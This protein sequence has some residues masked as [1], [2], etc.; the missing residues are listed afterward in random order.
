MKLRLSFR[1]L[2]LVSELKNGRTC[3]QTQFLSGK[4][5]I[6]STSHCQG[7]GFY[8]V[9]LK[10]RTQILVVRLEGDF[11]RGPAGPRWTW[12][13][14]NGISLASEETKESRRVAAWF[15]LPHSPPGGCLSHL[16]GTCPLLT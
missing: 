10:A 5:Q 3:I 2:I 16:W 14:G 11:L 9:M 1:D 6:A 7:L 8:P 15:S 13:R 4:P 12:N